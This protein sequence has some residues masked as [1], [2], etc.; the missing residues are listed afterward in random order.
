MSLCT[1]GLHEVLGFERVNVLMADPER[2]NLHFLLATGSEGFNVEG[3]TLP[4]D[5][6]IGI[7]N[8]CFTE[9]KFFLIDDMGKCPQDYY[10]QAPYV[11]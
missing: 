4:L 2:K 10:L 6:R 11:R 9:Q 8:K 1:E 3:V 5:Y 7:I